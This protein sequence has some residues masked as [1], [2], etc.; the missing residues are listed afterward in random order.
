MLYLEAFF[1][2][3]SILSQSFASV[4]MFL[5]PQWGEENFLSLLPTRDC[6]L[7]DRELQEIF[8]FHIETNWYLTEGIKRPLCSCLFLWIRACRIL[9]K[10]VI[11]IS[12]LESAFSEEMTHKHRKSNLL[13][14]H[15]I[16]YSLLVERRDCFLWALERFPHLEKRKEMRKGLRVFL[17]KHFGGIN[18][19]FFFLQ[20]Y[21]TILSI[22]TG[23]ILIPVRCGLVSLN[24]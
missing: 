4:F 12:S 10:D 22:T 13:K 14:T 21:V 2:P 17:I 11:S 15:L 18:L 3:F 9:K 20:K 8:Q 19:S 6:V 16:N 23:W 7:F 5:S 24:V 1:H